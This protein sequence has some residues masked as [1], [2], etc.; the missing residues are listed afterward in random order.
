MKKIYLT[1]LWVLLILMSGS[2]MAQKKPARIWATANFSKEKVMVGEPL[3]VTVSVYTSTWFTDPPKFEE[4]QVPGAIMVRLEENGGAVSTTIGNKQYAGIRQRFVLYPNIIGEN[5]L[6]SFTVTVSCPPEG[7]YK[8]IEREVS[9]KPR[10]FTVE[11]P[12]EGIELS[13]WLSAYSVRVSETWDRPLTSLKAGDL[14]ER[15]ITIRAQGALAAAIPEVGIEKPEFGSIYPKTPIL[16]NRQQARSFSG[17]RTEIISYLLE[18]DGN[19]TI[20]AVDFGWFD[21]RSKTL[22]TEH[23]DSIPIEIAVNPDLEFIL[24]RQKA[25]QEELAKEEPEEVAEEEPPFEMFGLNW[26][27]LLLVILAIISLISMLVRAIKKFKLKLEKK[28]KEKLLSEEHFFT[29][30]EA[31][32][33]KNDKKAVVS[34]F[35]NWYDRFRE[36]RYGPEVEEFLIASQDDE[37]DTIARQLSSGLY[38][39]EGEGAYSGNQ[40]LLKKVSEARKRIIHQKQERIENAWLELNPSV[41]R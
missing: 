6:P 16:G 9:T 38:G 40:A 34:S 37:L 4:I 1:Y 10:S 28:R 27:Q 21:L 15:R 39:A 13:N 24:T 33:G 29:L 36:D 26:W 31:A 7:D 30:F 14:L 17:T 19:F 32:C 5:T 23:L 3:V 25:L 18:S 8:G 12:P 2:M 20:P 22:K 11:P 41:E 35:L